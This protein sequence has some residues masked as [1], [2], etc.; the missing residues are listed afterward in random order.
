MPDRRLTS[1]TEQIV[2][3]LPRV[4]VA[5]VRELGGSGRSLTASVLLLLEAGI[6][7]VRGGSAAGGLSALSEARLGPL[8]GEIAGVLRGDG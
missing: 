6:A 1:R 2:V 4:L 3:R 5:E 7:S 8:A